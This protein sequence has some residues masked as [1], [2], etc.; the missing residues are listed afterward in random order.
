[1]RTVQVQVGKNYDILIDRNILKDSGTF[2][3]NV[4][5]RDNV[6]AAI[7]SDSNVAPLYSEIVINSLK[8]VGYETSLFVFPAGEQSKKLSTIEKMYQHFSENS[9]T[10]KDIV[11]A[12]GGGVTG[13]MAGFAAATYL[14]GIDFVQIP[15]TL[16]SQVDSSVGGKTGVDTDFGKNLVGAFWQ[17]RLV[18]IDINTL[19][20]LSNRVF[21]DGMGE[22]IK[23]G[24]I[25]SKSLF[26]KLEN[27][28]I[29][30]I[31]EDVIE[32]CVSIKKD[33]VEADE[34]ET[35]GERALLNFGHTFGHSI[36][37]LYNFSTISHGEA[38]SIGS[39]I[40]T[41]ASEKA[42]LTKSGCLD[43][44][45][46]LLKKYNLPTTTDKSIL[47]IANASKNDKKSGG[48]SIGL[49]L[50]DDIGSS[51]IYK[52]KLEDIYNFINCL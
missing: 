51:F 31:I 37:K 41:R 24:C 52:I 13:D 43:R 38:I 23:Y 34:K 29:K 21:C 5:K 3:K 40:I 18:I 27:N 50:I 22:V 17:P 20:T 45:E 33:V 42:N 49:V 47:D 8:S 16:L 1:M 44:I 2:I 32:E 39:C 19:D 10:R 48:T 36:E 15:T 46:N 6:R 12:L 26:E 9:L 30:D 7:V 35:T 25:K 11:V 14:R 4:F 28:N